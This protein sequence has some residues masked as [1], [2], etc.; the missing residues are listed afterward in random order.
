MLPL[1]HAAIKRADARG[2][3]HAQGD[4]AAARRTLLRSV[5]DEPSHMKVVTPL[6]PV[7]E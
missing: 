2:Y 5:F 6:S 7:H 4:L 3:G 1:A